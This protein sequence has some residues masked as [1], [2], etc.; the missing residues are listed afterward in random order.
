MNNPAVKYGVYYG[1]VLILLSIISWLLIPSIHY[2][3]TM[4]EAGFGSL[5][6]FVLVIAFLYLSLKETRHLQ[7][8]FLSF[9]EGLKSSFITYMIGTLIGT[10][11]SYLLLNYIAPD[12]LTLQKESSIAIA[13]DMT[14]WMGDLSGIP[15]EELESLND[16]MEA[17]L[18]LQDFGEF[19]F[20]TAI[21]TW[22]S[23]LIGGLIL[24]LI[25]SAIMKKND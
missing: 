2:P 19:G 5:L 4:K 1:A 3:T 11:F 23:S 24:S 9:G 17:E 6:S 14:S 13:N 15:E 10:I 20:G 7:E 16:N 8:G 25:M 22:L 21:L 12:L 18:E